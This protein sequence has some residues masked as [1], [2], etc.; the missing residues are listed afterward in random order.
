[1]QEYCN[2]LEDV[3]EEETVTRPWVLFTYFAVQDKHAV[4]TA[5][6]K[7]FLNHMSN[8]HT[9]RS[10]PMPGLWA[11]MV[12]IFSPVCREIRDEYKRVRDTVYES[13]PGYDYTY[14]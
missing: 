5:K 8:L 7:K 10:E 3:K 2:A 6:V 12:R 14:Y 11:D 4:L 9:K 1:M 13:P